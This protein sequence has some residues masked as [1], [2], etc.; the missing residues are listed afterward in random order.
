MR[1]IIILGLLVLTGSLQAQSLKDALFGGKLKNDSGAV[2]RKTDTIQIKEN[3]ARK[4]EADTA[5]PPAPAMTRDSAQNQDMAATADTVA[6]PAEAAPVDAREE[7]GQAT[8]AAPFNPTLE[9]NKLWKAFVAEY[10]PIIQS[11]IQSSKK[12]KNGTYAVLIDY[13]IGTDGYVTTLNI[14]VSPKNSTLEE[15]IRMRMMANAP[16]FHPVLLSNGKP[17]KVLKKQSLTFVKEKN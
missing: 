9:N 4:L 2:L 12:L 17:R 8:P 5:R 11:E 6:A 3:M 15:L 1:A 16:Q 13:E 14:F 7:A 10:T